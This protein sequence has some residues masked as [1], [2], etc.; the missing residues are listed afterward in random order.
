MS[1]WGVYEVH[2]KDSYYVVLHRPTAGVAFTKPNQG[3]ATLQEEYRQLLVRLTQS[4][5]RASL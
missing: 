3:V 4:T 1:G 5:Q 2:N